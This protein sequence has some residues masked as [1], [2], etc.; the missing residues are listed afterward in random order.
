[1]KYIYNTSIKTSKAL[2]KKGKTMKAIITLRTNINSYMA[3]DF[4]SGK[5]ITS[6][7]NLDTLKEFCLNKGYTEFVQG[8]DEEF[9]SS[10]TSA[11]VNVM[12]SPVQELKPKK[13]FSV[14]KRFY[15]LSQL[16]KMIVK[17]TAS[18]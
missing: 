12:S 15:F 1:M 11:P 13:Q 4:L 3:K 7:K 17:F 14:E 18:I 9:V 5:Q 16:T 8:P 6:R 10:R 2:N